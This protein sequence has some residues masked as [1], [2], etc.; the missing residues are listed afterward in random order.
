VDG[1]RF[2]QEAVNAGAVA[3]LSD[4]YNPFT[5][6][7]Y[8]IVFSDVLQAEGILASAYY[9]SPAEQLFLVG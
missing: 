2:I 4:L 3:V 9:G 5:L 7:C 6:T 1:T 8:Q